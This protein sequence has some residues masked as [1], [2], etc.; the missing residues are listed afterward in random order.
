MSEKDENNANAKYDKRKKTRI[1]NCES[2]LFRLTTACA[3]LSPNTWNRDTSVNPTPKLPSPASVRNVLSRDPRGMQGLLRVTR[4]RNNTVGNNVWMCETCEPR[5][6]DLGG[7]RCGLEEEGGGCLMP[8]GGIRL[9]LLKRGLMIHL[10]LPVHWFSDEVTLDTLSSLFNQYIHCQNTASWIC[11]LIPAMG[12]QN[13]PFALTLQI[14]LLLP[15]HSCKTWT[16]CCTMCCWQPFVVHRQSLLL[17]FPLVI[18]RYLYFSY[19][20]FFPPNDCYY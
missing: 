2:P 1:P 3:A 14:H 18:L 12:L 15:V 6:E 19:G 13:R 16:T 11:S 5:Q 20:Y 8:W 4:R 9:L 17:P 7:G 10:F